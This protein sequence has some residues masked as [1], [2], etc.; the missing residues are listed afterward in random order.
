MW[1]ILIP[2]LIG[3]A[4][5]YMSPGRQDKSKMFVRGAIWAVII[6]AVIVLLGKVFNVNPLGYGDVGFVGL[7]I[8][9]VVSILVFLVGVWIGDMIEGRRR[10]VPPGSPPR[11]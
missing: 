1:G 2:L 7:V 6:A 4:V 10:T 11:V 3:I 8:S 9:F 5:G